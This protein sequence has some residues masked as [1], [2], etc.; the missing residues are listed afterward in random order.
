[1]AEKTAFFRFYA[2]LNDFLPGGLRRKPVPYV[3]MVSP[4]VKD[5]IESLGVPHPEVDLV[6]A[7]GTSVGFDYRVCNGDRVAVY[8]VFES[9][10]ISPVLK[11]R[12][13]P[14]RTTKFVLDTHL[15]KL[16]RLL[17]MLGF[18]SLYRQDFEDNEIIHLSVKEH[19]I[20]LTRDTTLLKAGAVTHGYWIRSVLPN[21]QVREVLDRFDLYNNVRPFCRCMV[22]NSLITKIDKGAVVTDIPRK[23]R[24]LHNEFYRC[25]GCRKIYWKG[26]HYTDMMEQ[27]Q[28]LSG[29]RVKDTLRGL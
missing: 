2:E 4:S 5:A 14:L 9:V 10:D 13:K 28:R 8:P 24:E 27:I 26:S 15:G 1:V 19:R 6:V 7:N 17:R 16:A 29:E 22:C 3:F 18:D 20:I 25:A 11:L 23:V 12:P 21:E